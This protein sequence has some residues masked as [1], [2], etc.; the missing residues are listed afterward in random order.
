MIPHLC[1][2]TAALAVGACLLCLPVRLMY[3]PLLP[4]APPSLGL[5]LSQVAELQDVCP[6]L[7]EE[8]AAKALDFCNGK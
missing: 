5:S 8:E 7:S 2:V 4:L 6:D 1:P 3:V